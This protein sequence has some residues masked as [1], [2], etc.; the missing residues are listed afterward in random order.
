MLLVKIFALF[1]NILTTSTTAVYYLPGYPALE[2]E[3]VDAQA[4][5]NDHGPFTERHL[6]GYSTVQE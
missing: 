2:E 4:A 6:S 1:P 5:G 3:K